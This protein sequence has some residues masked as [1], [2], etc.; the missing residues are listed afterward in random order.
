MEKI[1]LGK[2]YACFKCGC[3]F[4]D[5]S[6]PQP[7]CPKCG[8]DQNEA[9]RQEPQQASRTSG[10]LPAA[11]PKLRRKREE[12]FEPETDFLMDEEP[13]TEDLGEDLTLIE[14]EELLDLGDD[15]FPDET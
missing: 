10:S 4:Y 11:R 14:D 12:T 1:K 9:P 6:R 8:A 7:I 2:K 5:L 3:K 13:V 15:D